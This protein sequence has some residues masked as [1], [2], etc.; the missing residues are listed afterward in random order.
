[1]CARTIR[2]LRSI[3]ARHVYISNLPLA[4]ANQTLTDILALVDKS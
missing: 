4:R 2:E 1:V 3:G